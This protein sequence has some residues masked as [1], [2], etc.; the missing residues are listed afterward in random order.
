MRNCVILIWPLADPAAA[1]VKRTSNAESSAIRLKVA[2]FYDDNDAVALWR[3]KW[4][5]SQQKAIKG[6]R[7]VGNLAWDTYHH[8]CKVLLGGQA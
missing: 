3:R 8:A 1:A 6:G 2:R 7:V 4:D 5:P